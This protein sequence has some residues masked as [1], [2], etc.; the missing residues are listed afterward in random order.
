VHLRK[1][2]L[3]LA[4]VVAGA[5]VF[6]WPYRKPLFYGILTIFGNPK[7]TVRDVLA[8]KANHMFGGDVEDALL[9]K[10]RRVR[11]EPGGFELWETPD[12]PYWVPRGHLL[13]HNL[14]EQERGI[15][16]GGAQQSVRPGDVV[17]DCGANVGLFTRRALKAGASLVVAVEPSPENLLCLRRNFEAEVG[18][19]TVRIVSKG[20]FDHEGQLGFR[21]I[22]DNTT[23]NRFVVNP[24]PAQAAGLMLLPITTIDRLVEELPLTR[25]D[26]IKMDIE[27][28]EEYAIKGALQTLKRFRP[29]M[30]I[31][32]YH[33]RTDADVIPSL[34][35][36]ADATYRIRCGT[37]S[38]NKKRLRLAPEVMLFD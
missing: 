38:F 16:E 8:A 30:A 1:W 11:T 37:C 20:V 7:C 31:C 21:I 5:G 12:G 15:Y 3:L 26:F 4:L 29:R 32:V 17:I 23:G 36:S 34:V 33:R 9:A 10:M 18:T 2:L 28:S 6:G 35:A 19:G 14:S 25:V 13:S 22:G 24:N 27:G